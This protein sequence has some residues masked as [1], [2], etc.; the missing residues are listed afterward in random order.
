MAVPIALNFLQ[1]AVT[2]MEE[3]ALEMLDHRDDMYPLEAVGILCSDG[4]TYRLIN[5]SRSS[6]RFTVSETL[7]REAIEILTRRGHPPVAIYHSHPEHDSHPSRRDIDM[8]E[9]MPGSL[10]VIVGKEGIAGW[11]WNDGLESVGKIPHPE[12]TRYGKPD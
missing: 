6:H 2:L 7:V 9:T 8:M 11:R 5:Q 4:V 3:G 12:R 1:A 10:S